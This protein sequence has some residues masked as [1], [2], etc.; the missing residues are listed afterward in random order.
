MENAKKRLDERAERLRKEEKDLL[1]KYDKEA[2]KKEML[3]IERLRLEQEVIDRDFI[4]S[5]L[6]RKEM[7]RLV[8]LRIEQENEKK[9]REKETKRVS[10]HLQKQIDRHELARQNVGSSTKHSVCYYRFV[11]ACDVS[12]TLIQDLFIDWLCFILSCP[13]YVKHAISH[14]HHKP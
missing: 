11:Y 7:D 1:E 5:E 2:R 4:D 8:Q 13:K 9:L 14:E 3:E 10:K 6:K 12:D